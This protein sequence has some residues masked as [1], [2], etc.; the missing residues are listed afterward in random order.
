MCASSR[1][2]MKSCLAFLKQHVLPALVCFGLAL[3]L[4]QMDSFQRFENVTFDARAR[5]RTRYFPTNPRDDVVLVGIDQDSLNQFGRWPWK[6]TVHGDFVQ[7]AGRLK[8]SAIAF[9]LLFDDADEN[10]A[11]FAA[12]ITRSQT[13]VVLA[14]E[15]AGPEGGIKPGSD[16]LKKLRLEP[17]PHVVGDRSAI[18]DDGAMSLPLAPLGEVADLAF[19]TVPRA[20][21]G[22][23][24]EAPIVLRYGDQV[25]PS[26]SLR[27]LMHHWHV[28]PDDVQVRLGDA[29]VIK[30]DFVNHRIPIDA[31]GKYLINYR[32]TLEGFNS[33][34][35]S[36]SFNFLKA[37][38]VE[39]K[40]VPLPEFTGRILLVG[41]IAD[42]LS[43]FGAT[44]LASHTPGV[45]VHA[46]VLENVLNG[47]FA[48]RAAAWPIWLGGFA[49]TAASLA[50]FA[51]RK[52]W[53]QIAFA[54]GVPVIFSLVTMLAWK[55]LSLWVPVVWPTLGFAGAQIFRAVRIINPLAASS[56]ASFLRLI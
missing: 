26:L 1:A 5:L 23:L 31:S 40:D 52:F 44:P 34:G 39:K 48:R 22:V 15:P 14:S 32:H 2:R 42:G 11:R 12:S 54:I 55:T 17:L 41:Q 38:Y 24:R 53:Q 33:A 3:A 20:E 49:I 13:A 35:F 9:D 4:A 37:K 16:A 28:T 50:L 36:E 43:D 27:S 51:Q 56:L 29:V 7:L 21:D 8:P 10:D 45:L 47:D 6:R 19:A 18:D 25:Y 30:N 46:N